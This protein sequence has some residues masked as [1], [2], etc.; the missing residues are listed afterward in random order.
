[1]SAPTASGDDAEAFYGRLIDR[2]HAARLPF[3]VGGAYAVAHYTGIR[4][5]TKDVDVFVRR[6]D[7]P[8]LAAVA[9]AAGWRCDLTFPHWLGKVHDASGFADVIFGCGNGLGEVDDGWFDH[10]V[11]AGVLGRPVKLTPV[12]ETL[13]TKAFIMERERFD[14]ADVV[15]L[16]QACAARID[17][18]RLL[19][20]FAGHWRVLLAH[21]VLYGFVFPG[22]RHRVPR[23]VMQSLLDLLRDEVDAP[24]PRG[25]TCAGTLLSREQY[26]ADVDERGYDDARLAPA[27]G[28]SAGDVARWT[29]GIGGAE[30]Q[31]V[32]APAVPP[33]S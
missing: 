22:E 21:L 7:W 5:P 15:H 10:A 20:R 25:A 19:L 8:R 27:G 23:R 9:D 26:L 33:S 16:L 12:E 28:L 31:P 13:W 1:M 14:G 32:R 4:R 18:D 29:A 30:L 24:S 17:W 3:L 6:A 11:D 2:L